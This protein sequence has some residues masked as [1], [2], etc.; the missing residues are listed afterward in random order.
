MQ[1]ITYIDRQSGETITERPPGEGYLKWLYYNPLGKLA[2]HAV[3]KRKLLSTIYGRMMDSPSSKDK[4]AT[5]VDDY[6]IDMSEAVKSVDSFTS[7]N[8]FFYRK[9]RPEARPIGSGLVSPADGKLLAFERAADVG[10]FFVKGD[11][12]TLESYLRDKA[13]ANKYANSYLIIV[14]LAPNDYHRYHFPAAG[15]PSATTSINGRYYS[16][17]PYALAPNFTRVFCENKREYLELSTENYGDILLSPV[18]ATMVGTM[19]ST[20]TAHQAINGGDEM[21]YFAF[22]GSTIVM[23]VDRDKVK[24]DDDLIINTKAKVETAVK[25][26]ESIGS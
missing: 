6:Q 18:A 14:R 9:L 26:G 17:S 2:L 4:I 3:V 24:I 10:Q 23:L 13:L 1:T 22:G 12:F 7:F 15:T 16:V 21:G 11:P 19:V 5:F 25:M 20:H 8:D